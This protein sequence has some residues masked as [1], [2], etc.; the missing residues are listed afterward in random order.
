[1]LKECL[2]LFTCVGNAERRQV[3]DNRSAIAK[4]CMSLSDTIISPNQSDGF[5]PPT[6]FSTETPDILSESTAGW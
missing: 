1:M 2:E 3:H 4:A 5:G 6:K